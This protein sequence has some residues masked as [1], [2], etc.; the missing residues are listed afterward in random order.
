[1]QHTTRYKIVFKLQIYFAI[2]FLRDK[3]SS[4]DVIGTAYLPLSEISG[5]GDSEG[6]D[7]L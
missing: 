1:M 3:M 5:E 7:A 4:D 6:I 2:Y